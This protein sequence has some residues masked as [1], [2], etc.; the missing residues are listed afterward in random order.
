MRIPLVVGAAAVLLL[1][2]APAHAAP[3]WCKGGPSRDKPQYDMKSLFSETQPRRALTNLIGATCYADADIASYAKQIEATRLAWSK[4]LGLTDA[5]WVDVNE[6]AHYPFEIRNMNDVSAKNRQAPWSSFSAL[7]QFGAL[8]SYSMQIDHAYVADAFGAKLTQ[9]GRL[10][11]VNTCLQNKVDDD[12]AAVWYA[13]CAADVAALDEAKLYAEISADKT[14]ELAD[15][16]AVR[17]VTYETLQMLPAH[18]A[19]VQALRAK[20]PAYDKMFELA[21]QAQKQWSSAD[22]KIVALMADL[23]DAHVSGSRKASAGCM[24]RAEEAWKTVVE[25]VPTKALASIHGEAG[26]TYLQQMLPLVTDKPSGYLAAI[27]L[28]VCANLE[29]KVDALTRAIGGAFVRWPGFRGPRTGAQT[30][31]L[32]ANLQLDRRE[33]RIEYPRL[34]REF[35]RGDG[36]SSFIGTAA[37]SG[38]K[39]EGEMATITFAKLKVRQ[40]RCVKGHNTNRIQRVMDSGQIVYEYV[41]DKYIDETIEVPPSAPVTV[42][43]K[44]AKG[45]TAGMAVTVSEDVVA[46]AY[47]KNSATPSIVT[48]VV[49]K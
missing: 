22:P 33:G 4:K 15:R 8:S 35:I 10:S 27:A 20:D 44:Y 18:R 32:T 43:A 2:V 24:T 1:H 48:G 21:E 14:H 16:M 13:M 7:D 40:N 30:A 17:M 25:A 37:I 9:L 45:L 36:N 28:N 31:I 29:D 6:W 39:V 46:A 38:V 41:C 5:D 12:D 47:P 19:N 3:A 23:D 11:Y 26:N 42:R 49:V 34:A